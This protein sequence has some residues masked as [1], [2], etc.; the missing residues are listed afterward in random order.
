MGAKNKFRLSN[1]GDIYID[2]RSLINIVK[3]IELVCIRSDY[4]SLENKQKKT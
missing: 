2:D 4:E 3:E 1:T